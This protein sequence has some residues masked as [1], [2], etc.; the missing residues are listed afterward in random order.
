[1]AVTNIGIFMKAPEGWDKLQYPKNA[2]ND[3]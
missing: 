2:D 1:M 3:T